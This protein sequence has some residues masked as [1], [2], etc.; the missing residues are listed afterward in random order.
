MASGDN[1]TASRIALALGTRVASMSPR[2]SD[3]S[4]VT[5]TDTVADTV[6]A[7]L[8]SGRKY[9]IRWVGG[10]TSTVAADSLFLRIR[11]DSTTAGTQLMISRH[12]VPNTSG[13][14]SR[15]GA[16]LE[17]EYTA[18]ATGSKSFCLSYV[19]ASGSGSVSLPSTGALPTYFY[20]EYVEG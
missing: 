14:G 18:G 5:T 10:V 15:F 20:V 8:V 11:E 6:T 12:G 1:L 9:R 16:I 4:A 13:A 7:D 3:S 2:T 17:A 19:R